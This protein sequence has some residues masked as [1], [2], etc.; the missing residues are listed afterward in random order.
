MSTDAMIEFMHLKPQ[1]DQDVGGTFQLPAEGN[2]Y[3]SA[4]GEFH[5]RLFQNNKAMLD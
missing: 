1:G 4:Q 3:L 5:D 2:N